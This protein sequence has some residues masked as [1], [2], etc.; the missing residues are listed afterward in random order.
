MRVLAIAGEE[1]ISSAGGEFC[2]RVGELVEE[3]GGFSKSNSDVELF[4]EEPSI[5]LLPDL[6]ICGDA[7][8]DPNYKHRLANYL[9]ILAW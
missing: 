2:L 3:R 1:R 6:C 4:S 9:L 7:F 8:A 5:R